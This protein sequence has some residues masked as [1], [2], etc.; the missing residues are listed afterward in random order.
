MIT[1]RKENSENERKKI[2]K[3]NLNRKGEFMNSLY[4]LGNGFDLYMGMKTR[5]NDFFKEKGYSSIRKKLREKLD[6]EREDFQINIL[7]KETGQFTKKI[8][9]L[10]Q[11]LKDL[12]ESV[13]K[14]IEKVE[15]LFLLYLIMSDDKLVDWKDVEKQI[16]PYI[17]Y[18]K[19]VLNNIQKSAEEIAYKNLKNNKNELELF[20]FKK[21]IDKK[22]DVSIKNMELKELNKFEKEFGE[23]IG[24]LEE[25][26]KQKIPDDFDNKIIKIFDKSKNELKESNVSVLTFNYTDYLKEYFNVYVNIHG[27]ADNPIFGIDFKS[28][29]ENQQ[30]IYFTKTSRVLEANIEKEEVNSPYI[31]GTREIVFF[32]HSLAEADYSYFQ[33]IFDYYDIY[34]SG[35]K[36]K[37][38]YHEHSVD[39]KEKEKMHASVMDLIN[40]YGKSLDNKDKGTNLLHKLLLESRIK[41]V[42]IK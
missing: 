33:S 35:I 23:Y 16:K 40:T 7:L 15:N 32:G 4:I 24:K 11:K 20:I 18:T 31:V 2:L 41:I 3:Y 14:I 5:Y 37:F 36:L 13:F 12:E 6:K 19:K 38:L 9:D 8:S 27:T 17:E 1:N 28:I 10:P 25:P 34:N 39:C 29:T 22:V 42:E 30:Y 21:F 26:L